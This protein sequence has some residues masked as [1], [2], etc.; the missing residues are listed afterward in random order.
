MSD[1]PNWVYD[2]VMTLERWR[3]EHPTLHADLYS[4]EA[5]KHVMQKLGDDGGC[6]ALGLVPV[7]V[8]ERAQAIRE[9]T[10]AA[11]EE[12]EAAACAAWPAI[13]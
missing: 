2:V 6:A 4:M 12:A 7:E 1:L 9:Y 11:A 3:D 13:E 10:R 5:G 8:R